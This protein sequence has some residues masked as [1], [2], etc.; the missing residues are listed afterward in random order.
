VTSIDR[1]RPRVALATAPA[2]L[3]DALR[4]L[5]A[6]DVDVTVLLTDSDEVFDIALTTQGA[7]A[8]RA[9]VLIEL[10]A[11]PSARGGGTVHSSRVGIPERLDDL[12]AV[13][14]FVRETAA[15]V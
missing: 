15:T 6:D 12:A 8:V 10:D 2:L 9:D 4:S 13:L 3:T 1:H 7:P 5:M 11:S 14:A